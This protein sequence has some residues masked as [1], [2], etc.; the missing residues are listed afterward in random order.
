MKISKMQKILNLFL[1]VEIIKG[2]LLFHANLLVFL[3][4][5]LMEC[6]LSLK[7]SQT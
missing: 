5:L 6:F 1:G 4:Y 2:L 3:K 7:H